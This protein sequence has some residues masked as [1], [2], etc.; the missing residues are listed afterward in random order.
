[1][2]ECAS[3]LMT[4]QSGTH[5]FNSM[6]G[7]FGALGFNKQNV[8]SVLQIEKQHQNGSN[9]NRSP[10][11]SGTGSPSKAA[12][13]EDTLTSIPE[14]DVDLNNDRN[15]NRNRAGPAADS[16]MIDDDDL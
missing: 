9:H 1:M 13:R 11:R 15:R 6:L 10:S 2:I 12:S 3:K 5:E 7:M 16:F 14:E 4:L 8:Q